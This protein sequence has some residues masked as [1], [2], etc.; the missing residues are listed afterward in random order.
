[1]QEADIEIQLSGGVCNS[2]EE[3]GHSSALLGGKNMYRITELS[4]KVSHAHEERNKPFTIHHLE[5]SIV[6][7]KRS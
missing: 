4:P 3:V 6:I 1:M 2:G 5:S 7:A